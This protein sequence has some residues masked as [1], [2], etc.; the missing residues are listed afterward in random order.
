[1]RWL[2]L[3]PLA[4]IAQDRPKALVDFLDP[5]R[6]LPPEYRA[7][8]ALRLA[9]SGRLDKHK[10]W[11]AEVIEEAFEA[12][13]QAFDPFPLKGGWHTD[14]RSYVTAADTKLDR[15][16]LR[17][18]AVTAMMN[19]DKPR[20]T[21]MFLR[22]PLEPLPALDCKS[23]LTPRLNPYYETMALVFEKGFTPEQRKRGEHTTLLE[24]AV[25]GLQSALQ[26]EPVGEMVLKLQSQPLLDA[27]G[28][29]L[30]QIERSPRTF[31]VV[32]DSPI[33]LAYKARNSKLGLLPYVK[34]LH[35][36]LIDSVPAPQCARYFDR[37]K[38]ESVGA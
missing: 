19:V 8:L 16:S 17:M 25:A 10:D 31:A 30:K 18:R 22:A 5:T 37:W 9:E 1:M 38:R 2:F 28:E 27:L 20:A 11:K 3:L 34:G 7:D 13:A 23:P 15:L 26:I 32:Q 4:L 14:Q 24:S 29:K 35:A 21:A 36:Y 33:N 12:A 6:G